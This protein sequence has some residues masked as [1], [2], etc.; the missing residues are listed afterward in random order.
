MSLFPVFKH[1]PFIYK[2]VLEKHDKRTWVEAEKICQEEENGHLLT[3]GDPQE[4][5]WFNR[6]VT[7]LTDEMDYLGR[8]WLGATDKRL[9]GVYEY[10]D[11]S[12]FKYKEAPWAKG[13]PNRPKEDQYNYCIVVDTKGSSPT[14]KDEDCFESFGYVCKSKGMK[15]SE[16]D[17]VLLFVVNWHCL[18]SLLLSL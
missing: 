17:V 4:S 5:A 15:I 14:W 6:L 13:E 10:I 3:L 1:G 11:G 16:V 8:L 12:P 2:V 18:S 7:N 9:S